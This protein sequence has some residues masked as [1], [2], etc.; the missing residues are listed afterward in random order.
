MKNIEVSIE[1]A[2]IAVMGF[3]LPPSEL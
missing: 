3:H 2:T 1:L